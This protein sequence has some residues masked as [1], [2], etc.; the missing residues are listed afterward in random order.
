MI[1]G[2]KERNTSGC[3]MM[4]IVMWK[5]VEEL[6]FENNKKRIW[7]IVVI[8]RHG[9]VEFCDLYAT[10]TTNQQNWLS[11]VHH[12]RSW[13]FVHIS[14]SSGYL[15]IYIYGVRSKKKKKERIIS[16]VGGYREWVQ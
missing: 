3:C 4:I 13:L 1:I 8:E 7:R 2:K 14:D 16:S 9:R 12:I 6:V 10:N 11:G 15:F 5:C